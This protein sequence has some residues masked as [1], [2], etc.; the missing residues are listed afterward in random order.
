MGEKY[1]VGVESCKEGGIDF[2][3]INELKELTFMICL[4]QG[5]GSLRI[6]KNNRYRCR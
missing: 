1:F 4:N 5:F 2:V 6:W 3:K